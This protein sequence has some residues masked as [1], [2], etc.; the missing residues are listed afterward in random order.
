MPYDAKVILDSIS[1]AGVRLTT[2]EL[3]YPR[4]VHSE[5]LT[6]RTLSRNSSSSR[7]IPVTKMLEQVRNAPAGPVWWGKNQKGMQAKEQLQGCEL[8][9]A[10]EV[11]L[12]ARDAMVAAAE[13]LQEVGL[14]KQIANR[15]LEPWMFIRVVVTATDWANFF[16]QRCHP[17][18][19]P[20]IQKVAI[21]A[22]DAR[23]AST[24]VKVEAG[25][26]HLPYIRE[27]DWAAVLDDPSVDNLSMGLLLKRVSVARCA[28][29]SYLT[30]DGRRDLMEDLR[31]HDQ[32][33]AT[34]RSDSP[35]HFS[36]FEHVATP[37]PDPYERVGNLRG[38]YQ[39]RQEFR[40]QAGPP[41]PDVS[42]LR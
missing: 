33:A 34:A 29:V 12:K 7:A 1:P 31:L 18:A 23:D 8:A 14:H 3:S 27:E 36:P 15:L 16:H 37:L 19:Q 41:D 25:A 22:R 17:D 11:W 4:F 24:P 6:H 13:V 21:M 42:N 9:K 40:N 39:Y 2:M 26:W 30:H 20:E 10:Q 5:L 38:W 32:L 28:R 35:G